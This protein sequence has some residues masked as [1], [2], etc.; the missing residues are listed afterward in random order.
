MKV[1]LIVFA[2][3]LALTGVACSSKA[4]PSADSST[5]PPATTP[6]ASGSVVAVVGNTFEPK[7]LTVAAGTEVTFS[8]AG[9]V[10]HNVVADD[11][12]FNSGAAANTGTFK[13]TFGTAGTT[14]YYCAVHGGKGGIGMAGTITVA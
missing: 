5:T 11:D 7:D 13:H 14:K 8:W 9:A 6:P 4:T 10:P 3:L 2:A 1:R 12:S